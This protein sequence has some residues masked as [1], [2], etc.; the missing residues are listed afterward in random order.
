MGKVFS[1]AMFD[2]Q[3]VDWSNLLQILDSHFLNLILEHDG[4]GYSKRREG[5]I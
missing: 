5:R 2:Y 4:P 1:I 3:R